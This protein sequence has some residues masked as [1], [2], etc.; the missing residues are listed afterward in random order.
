[1]AR[2]SHHCISCLFNEPG[3]VA[4]A[5]LL[6]VYMTLA[7]SQ[8][9]PDLVLDAVEAFGC[10]VSG[11]SYPLNSY[12]NRVF[13]VGL[14]AGGSVVA[15]FYRPQRWS[16]AQ[17]REEHAFTAHL[18]GRG[19][20]VAEQL[21]TDKGESVLEINGFYCSLQPKIMGREPELE[22]L[23]SLF[24]IGQAIGKMHLEARDY[25][26]SCRGV[27]N[28]SEMGEKNTEYLLEKWLPVKERGSYEKQAERLIRAINQRLPSDFVTQFI[29]AHGDC[30]LSNVLLTGDTPVLLDFDD[31]MM[32]PAV[33][34]LWMFLPGQAS[35]HRRQLS[36]L[37][38]GYEEFLGFP[39]EQ[40][41]WIPVLRSLRVINYTAWL[42]KRW[43]DPAFPRAF[44]W[45]NSQGFWQQH[46]KELNRL[47]LAVLES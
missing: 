8:L 9:Y 43:E 22:D 12:E 35:D 28:V 27:L 15:K 18:Q 40:L 6:R 45:F 25:A 38:E 11:Q 41:N 34:D 44:P 20:A 47:E 7:F 17:I 3:V 29:A 4:P 13:Q 23:E 32:A 30:H 26:F 14:Q 31:A 37:I 19:V 10:E 1:M 24:Q 39:E 21:K 42:A 36:E 16:I 5:L 2:Q 33:Q 46:I